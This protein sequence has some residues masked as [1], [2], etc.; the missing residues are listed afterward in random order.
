M[1]NEQ[2]SADRLTVSSR[3]TRA[4]HAVYAFRVRLLLTVKQD[5]AKRMPHSIAHGVEVGQEVRRLL[6]RQRRQQVLWHQ[7]YQ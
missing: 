7:G 3:R 1:A 5:A 6:C 2:L 4:K